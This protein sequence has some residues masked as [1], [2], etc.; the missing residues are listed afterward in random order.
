MKLVLDT[1]IL[2]AALIRDS[3]TREILLLPQVEFLVSEFVF[4]EVELHRDEIQRKSGLPA[5]A[6]DLLFEMMKQR[7]VLL[8]DN[9][10]KHK[11]EAEAIMKPIDIKDALFIA[12]ALSEENDGIWS[13]DKHF[14]QQQRVKVWKTKDLIEHFRVKQ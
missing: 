10:I 12:I 2:I 6:F 5:D 1:N 4:E 7:L 14:E 9:E 13:E 8:P 3:V 11:Q